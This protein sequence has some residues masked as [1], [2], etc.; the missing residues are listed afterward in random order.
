MAAES[1]GEFWLSRGLNTFCDIGDFERLTRRINGGIN[2]LK[3]RQ[4]WLVKAQKLW[5]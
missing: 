2:G 1:A 4:A 3:E 5:Q